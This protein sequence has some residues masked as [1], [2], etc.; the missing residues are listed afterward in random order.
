MLGYDRTHVLNIGY[1]YLLPTLDDS[2]GLKKAILGGWQ[3]TGV[4]TYISGAPLQ[5][6]ATTG[7]NFGIAGTGA[8]GEPLASSAVLTGS[9]DIAAMPVLTCDPREGVSGDQVLNPS[10][11]ALPTPGAN[12]NYI[13]PDLRGPGYT[14]HDFAVFKNFPMGG[15][16]K[17]QFRASL[18]N[19]FNHPQ[20]FFDDNTNLRLQLHQRPAVQPAVRRPAARQQVRPPH[21]PAGVQDVLLVP[22]DSGVVPDDSGVVT[23]RSR[24][25]FGRA[26][27]CLG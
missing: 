14:N 13:F 18:T 12:G 3:F 7:V 25:G 20:R 27:L 4:S 11:F 5:P 21:R 10:C 19:V 9:P 26:F 1:S 23:V 22:V 8:N 17:F 16:R 2:A 24:P 6:L 15:T